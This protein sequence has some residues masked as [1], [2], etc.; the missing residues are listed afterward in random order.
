[1]DWHVWD[2]TKRENSKVLPQMIL[3][4]F[5]NMHTK[6]TPEKYRTCSLHSEMFKKSNSL[7]F[8]CVLTILSISMTH[9]I[10][11]GGLKK[12][13]HYV[14]ANMQDCNGIVAENQ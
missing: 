11:L 13:M 12:L 9:F 8:L 2:S 14:N 7:R 1:M 5:V 4:L 3:Y 10:I 6:L